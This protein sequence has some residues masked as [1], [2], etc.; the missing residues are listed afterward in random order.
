MVGGQATCTVKI[1]AFSLQQIC[2]EIMTTSVF[3]LVKSEYF[4]FK[5]L[6][7]NSHCCME[8]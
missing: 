5:I 4:K 1:I 8:L 6:L 2:R 7:L 3:I